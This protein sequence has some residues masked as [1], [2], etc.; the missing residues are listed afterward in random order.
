MAIQMQKET[1]NIYAKAFGE[2]NEKTREA[3]NYLR[4]LTQEAV[5]YQKR[6]NE[7]SRTGS[8]VGASCL[9]QVLP[10]QVIGL[11]FHKN[12]TMFLF[13]GSTTNYA[14]HH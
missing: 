11:I 8:N 4:Y 6:V 7:A 9:G 5:S 3:S 13:L 14:N 10:Y 2:D 1:S 12:Q